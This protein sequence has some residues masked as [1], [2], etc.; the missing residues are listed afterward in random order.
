[1]CNQIIGHSCPFLLTPLTLRSVQDNTGVITAIESANLIQNRGF[2]ICAETG[3]NY[4]IKLKIWSAI[5]WCRPTIVATTGVM[6]GW[7]VPSSS[8]QSR[9]YF[10]QINLTPDYNR[11]FLNLPD[12]PMRYLDYYIDEIKTIRGNEGVDRLLSVQLPRIR[13]IYILPYLSD[14]NGLNFLNAVVSNSPYTSP[15]SSAPNTNSFVKLRD[16]RL[17]I[18]SSNI[19]NEPQQYNHQFFEHNA[20]EL[21]NRTNGN[22]IKSDFFSGRVNKTMF[23]K[24]YNAYVFNLARVEDEVSDNQPKSIKI[25]FNINGKQS[26]YY[27]FLIMLEYETLLTI[28]PQSGKV[29]TD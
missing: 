2:Q 11:K 21:L 15:L 19:L 4:K 20:L 5:G 7:G 14:Y 26:V 28:D 1:V 8:I 13:N 6:T 12:Y 9:I 16:L 27:D 22:S 25:S 29:I 10:P 18:G 23:E 24:C 17:Q 3:A